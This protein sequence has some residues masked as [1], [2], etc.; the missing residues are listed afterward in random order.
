M[1]DLKELLIMLGLA[2]GG[3]SHSQDMTFYRQKLSNEMVLEQKL[4]EEIKALEYRKLWDDVNQ[5]ENTDFAVRWFKDKKSEDK[6]GTSKKD[7]IN[8]RKKIKVLKNILEKD[9]LDRVPS[10]IQTL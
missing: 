5:K 3:P 4:K 9:S 8:T 2:V 6:L 1:L 10:Q 7:L